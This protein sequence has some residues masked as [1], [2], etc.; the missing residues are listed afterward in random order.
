MTR[1]EAILVASFLEQLSDRFSTDGC[2]DMW[3]DNN[4]E[5]MSIVTEAEKLAK[6]DADPIADRTGDD[7]EIGTSNTLILDYVLNRFM[8]ENKITKKDFVDV[9]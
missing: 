4:A 1:T 6:F 5:N 3:L 2:N 8:E 9:A 7:N